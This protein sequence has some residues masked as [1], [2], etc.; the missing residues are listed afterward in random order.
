[1]TA[2]LRHM[3]FEHGYRRVAFIAGTPGNPDAEVRLAAYRCVL[4]EAGIPFDSRLLRFGDFVRRSGEIA[5]ADLLASEA[6][7]DAVV[8]ANDGMAL[9]A[10][11]ALERQ[12]Y[13]LPEDVAITGFDDLSMGRLNDPP[14][15]TVT[16]PLQTLITLAVRTVVAQLRGQSVP[17]LVQ[18]SS[19]LVVRESCGCGSPR[20]LARHAAERSAQPPLAFVLEHQARILQGIHDYDPLRPA[21]VQVDAAQLYQDFSRYLSDPETDL[22]A[23]TR[24]LLREIGRDNERRQALLINVGLL[25][26]A[27]KP[28]LSPEL[29]DQLH[30][31]R[32]QISLTDTRIQVQQRLEIDQ[33]YSALMQRGEDFSNSLHFE[34]LRDGLERSLPELGMLTTSMFL[35]RAD[36]PSLL[37]PLVSLVDGVAL[38][39]PQPAFPAELLF[40]GGIPSALHRRTLL[41]F[42]LVLGMRCLGCCRLRVSNGQQR[43]RGRARSGERCHRQCRAAPAHREQHDAARTEDSRAAAARE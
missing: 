21:A 1:M 11:A 40:R 20:H 38:P 3:I 25:R 4:A 39:E 14:L 29:E 24:D 31:L 22:L 2:L 26:E 35:Y 18:L 9:G 15:T 41:L 5:M 10:M 43:L 12:G 37:Q 16:Q 27:L 30:E 36:D 7:P 13:R 17:S 34:G 19:Q 28:I 8:A 23:L 32:A 33:A 6:V 42:P